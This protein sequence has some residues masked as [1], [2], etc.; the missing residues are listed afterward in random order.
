MR[1]LELSPGSR[2]LRLTNLMPGMM[3]WI[4][5]LARIFDFE[6]LWPS[7]QMESSPFQ[8]FRL[9]PLGV[10]HM[11]TSTSMHVSRQEWMYGWQLVGSSLI[12]MISRLIGMI[13]VSYTHLR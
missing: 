9:Y 12:S 11:L 13:T 5:P 2:G 10:F 7:G 3:S 1:I 4:L 6:C 8:S